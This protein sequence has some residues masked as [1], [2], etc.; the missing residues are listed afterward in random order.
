MNFKNFMLSKTLERR[1]PFQLSAKKVDKN[2]FLK[3]LPTK[4]NL[5]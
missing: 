3:D 1:E 2:Y 5:Y 4:F